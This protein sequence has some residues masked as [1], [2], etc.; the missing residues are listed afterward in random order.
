[1][2]NSKF[3]RNIFPFNHFTG[4]LE[5]KNYDLIIKFIYNKLFNINVN[6]SKWPIKLK[7]KSSKDKLIRIRNFLKKCQ[8]AK[9]MNRKTNKTIKDLNKRLCYKYVF[10]KEFLK[11]IKELVTKNLKKY[12]ELSD[13]KLELEESHCDLL[14]YENS[15]KFEKHRDKVPIRKGNKLEKNY[16]GKYKWRYFSFILCLDSDIKFSM[17]D[18]YY[19]RKSLDTSGCTILY[20]MPN[21][22]AKYNYC[23]NSS[24]DIDFNTNNKCL[25]R[26]IFNETIKP[27]HFLLFDSELLHESEEILKDNFKLVL[28]LDYWVYINNSNFT[29]CK[30][31]TC[32][33]FLNYKEINILSTNNY[34]NYKCWLILKSLQLFNKDIRIYIYNYLLNACNEINYRIKIFCNKILNNYYDYDCLCLSCL[35]FEKEHSEQCNYE[36]DDYEYD[37]EDYFCNDNDR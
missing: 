20:K 12:R 25:D 31:V 11:N 35:Q 3:D 16:H 27:K 24:Q 17:I 36:R 5:T 33:P 22:F 23:I 8:L 1:M 18:K 34:N 15:G 32:N 30:C 37:Y 29:I 9:I 6:L 13:K 4:S 19:G 7:C 10:Q 26:H 2:F 21:D 28:K 14:L